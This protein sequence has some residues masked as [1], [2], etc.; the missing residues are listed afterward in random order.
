MKKI[1]NLAQLYAIA[2]DNWKFNPNDENTKIKLELEK[3]LLEA[4]NIK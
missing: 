4:A 1:D 3:Q 2:L